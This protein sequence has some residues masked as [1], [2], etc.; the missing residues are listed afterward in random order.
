MSERQHPIV[1]IKTACACGAVRLSVNGPIYSMLLCSCTDCQKAT[2]TGHAAVAIANPESVL[3]EGQTRSFARPADSGAIFT[4]HFC[5][6][7]GTP[8]YGVSSR[9]PRSLM[10]PA[11][12]LAAGDDWF[13]PSQL[14]FARS[15][16]NWD[17]VADALPRHQTYRSNRLA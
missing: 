5:P 15:H 4:R 11:G 17:F 16:H 13:A 6:E 1:D 8:I 14:I 3:V 7:C 12:L 2:G 10:L 9:A